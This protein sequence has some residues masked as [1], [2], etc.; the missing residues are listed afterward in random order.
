MPW[1]YS[2]GL[3]NQP[4]PSPLTTRGETLPTPPR[5][6]VDPEATGLRREILLESRL[7]FCSSCVS[8]AGRSSGHLSRGWAS[9]EGSVE[10]T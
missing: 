7:R 5:Q 4:L 3:H 10:S 9:R 8:G 1:L 2:D 6:L